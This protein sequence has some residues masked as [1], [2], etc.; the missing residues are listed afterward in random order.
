M[1][2]AVSI[3]CATALFNPLLNTPGLPHGILKEIKAGSDSNWPS[4]I[5]YRIKSSS[6]IFDGLGVYSNSKSLKPS[7]WEILPP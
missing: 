1:S 4:P 5:L 2:S 6:G 3:D 7:L